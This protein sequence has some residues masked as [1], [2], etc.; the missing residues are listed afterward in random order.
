MKELIEQAK[1]AV[2]TAQKIVVFTGAGI[3]AESGIP[4]FRGHGGLW[5]EYDP[6]IYADINYFRQDPTYYWSF[7][8]DVRV[9]G[10][11]NSKP[12]AAHKSIAE[13]ERRGK[14]ITVITQNIDGLHQSAGSK[15]VIELHGNTKL[16]GC[17]ECEADYIFE[18]IRQQ[19]EEQMPPRCEKCNG[20]LKP[21]V[22]FFGEA[23]PDGAMEAAAQH[24]AECD[25]F[26]VVGST[27]AVYPAA[28]L[29]LVAKRNQTALIIIN[30]GE[31][32]MDEI[33]DIRIDAKAGEVLSEIVG[34]KQQ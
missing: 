7:F 32:A 16:I 11:V 13:L 29:P 34:L 18:D 25:L 15:D 2:A 26:I 24:T 12:N 9:Q 27:L 10:L 20:V 21:R 19:I 5:K 8:R 31:T 1:Q 28:S 6:N 17:Q 30:L 4:T 14:L 22:V 23:L 3:S 33:A